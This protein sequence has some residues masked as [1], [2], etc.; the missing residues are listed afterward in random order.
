M[1][2]VPQLPEQ[3]DGLVPAQ[4]LL[5]QL[6]APLTDRVAR[7]TR[8][9]AVNGT[10]P[11]GRVLRDV[12]RKVVRPRFLHEAVL[13]VELVASHSSAPVSGRES[14]QLIQGRVHFRGARHN[15]HVSIAHQ[16]MTVL[17]EHTALVAQLRFLALRLLG[18]ARIRIRLGFVRFVAALFL[19]EVYFR[20]APCRALARA[21]VLGPKAL[22]TGPRFHQRA[23]HREVIIAHQVAAPRLAHDRGQKSFGN[24]SGKQAVAVLGEHR[25]YP[26][27]IV[28]AQ[29]HEPAEQEIVLHLL[30][31]LPL[32]A[33][34]VQQ[35]NHERAQKLLR[36]NRGSADVRIH[37]LEERRQ[38]AQDAIEEAP[39]VTQRMPRGH[40]VL[41]RHIAEHRRGLLIRT[42]H[43][44]SLL[45]DAAKITIA[46]S[47]VHR[48][49]TSFSATC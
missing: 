26:H 34:R 6:A 8:G 35:L 3:P 15:R 41:Q 11:V 43:R 17:H 46:T 10:A 42:A 4:A 29:A 39:V 33:D 22:V 45:P 49:A 31:Q 48:H 36:W 18:E 27:R 40:P 23:F 30:H 21:L 24:V 12:R 2:T 47:Q 20:V 16:A 5:H 28:N 14:V 7:V 1:P 37:L 32:A 13:V 9:A 38:F 25:S 44:S 19:A